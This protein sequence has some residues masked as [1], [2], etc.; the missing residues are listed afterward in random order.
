[1]NPSGLTDGNF[2]ID[3]SKLE[4]GESEHVNSLILQIRCQKI[5][6]SVFKARDVFPPDL[7]TILYHLFRQVLI[8]MSTT[9]ALTSVAGFL[10]LRMINPSILFPIE[11]GLVDEMPKEKVL[12]RQLILIAKV[13]QNLV[14][15]LDFHF[16]CYNFDVLNAL[17]FLF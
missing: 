3:P 12:R 10:F 14:N 15:Y 6:N 17:I 9:D 13:L 5:L 1:M 16:I 8:N 4:E 2:E 7:Q 11:H